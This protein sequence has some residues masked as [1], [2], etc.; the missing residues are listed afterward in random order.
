M[1]AV[2]LLVAASRVLASLSFKKLRAVAHQFGDVGQVVIV[3][4]AVSHTFLV[5]LDFH[6]LKQGVENIVNKTSINFSFCDNGSILF[7][8]L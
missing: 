2:D 5:Q 3:L 4:M 7:R 1:V 8:Q 6:I